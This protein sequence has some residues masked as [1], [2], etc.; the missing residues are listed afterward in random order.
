MGMTWYLVE[1]PV[2]CPHCTARLREKPHR[3]DKYLCRLC[4]KF[5]DKNDPEL[6]GI[7]TEDE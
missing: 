1:P 6:I 3:G 2:Y 7:K 5:Y 4:N